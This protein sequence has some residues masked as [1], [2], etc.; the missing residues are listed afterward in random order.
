MFRKFAWS[1][2]SDSESDADVLDAADAAA[3]DGFDDLPI[4]VEQ[5]SPEECGRVLRNYL[6]E[7]KDSATIM[8]ANHAC[9]IAYWAMKA[10]ALGVSDLALGPGKQSGKYSQRF[11][12]VTGALESK[13]DEYYE[14]PVQGWNRGDGTVSVFSLPVVP[15]QQIVQ[16]EVTTH[17]EILESLSRAKTDGDL[18]L[19]YHQHPVVQE[20]GPTEIVLPFAIYLDGLAFTRTD[21][22]VAFFIHLGLPNWKRRHLAALIRKTDLCVCGCKGWHTY[23]PIMLFLSWGLETLA[24]GVHSLHRHD[25]SAWR[26]KDA[27][28]RSF[29]GAAIGFRAVCLWL[30]CDMMEMCTRMGFPAHNSSIGFCPLCDATHENWDSL[31][32]LSPVRELWNPFT[33]AQYN[34]ACERCEKSVVITD[35][36]FPRLKAALL[37]EDKKGKQGRVLQSDINVGGVALLKGDRLEPFSGLPLVVRFDAMRPPFQAIFWRPFLESRTR[38]RHPLFR[39]ETYLAP[40]NI[41][42]DWLHNHS[43]GVFQEWLS[44]AIHA[45]CRANVYEVPGTT[46]HEKLKGTCAAIVR[47]MKAWGQKELREGREQNVLLELTP[48]MVGDEGGS[49]PGVKGAETNSFIEF[50]WEELSSGIGHKLDKSLD[51]MRTSE[52]LY[53]IRLLLKLEKQKWPVPTAQVK[54]LTF[55]VHHVYIYID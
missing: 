9:L 32:E 41:C 10:G 51:W 38:H 28:G 45:M 11:D 16:E 39:D 8:R 46:W 2:G 7:L 40:S 3:D 31:E 53:K 54:L 26:D 50:M 15:L 52:S 12:R 4:P 20:A 36:I 44:G 14:L 5:M 43:L 34:E 25:G 37:Y 35:E 18:P 21:G 19:V 29:A 24:A 27:W 1:R 49:M 6:C 23:Y 55:H 48:H 42:V 22:C 17:P 33:A 30:K 47:N 13:D